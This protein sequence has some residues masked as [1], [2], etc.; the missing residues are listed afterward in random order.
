MR[1]PGRTLRARIVWTTAIVTALAMAAMIG[2]VVLVLNV[3]ATR[4]VNTTLHDRLEVVMASLTTSPDGSLSEQE[5]ANDDIDDTTWIFDANGSQVD[6]P[7]AGKRVQAEA[8]SLAMVRKR[9]SVESHDRVYLAAPVRDRPSGKV[10]G[11]VLVTESMAP[12]ETTRIA[13]LAVLVTLGLLV[14]AGSAAVAAWA[15]RRTLIPVESMAER[16][17]DWSER[18]LDARFDD[19]GTAD[20]F[21]VLGHTLNLLLDRVA[22]ALRKEQQLTS[23]LAHELRTPLTAIRGEAE[24]ALM[25]TPDAASAERFQRVVDLSDRMSTTITSLLAIARGSAG[26]P[27]RTTVADL[28]SAALDPR[29]PHPG[30]T[31]S[32]K[33][34]TED[35]ISAPTD[36]ALRALSPLVD[37]AFKYASTTVTFTIAAHSRSVDITVSDDGDGVAGAEAE[38]VFTSGYRGPTSDG[39]GLGLALSRRVARSLGGDVHLTSPVA[40]TSFTLTLPRY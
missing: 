13:V 16:A 4:S 21:A 33:H 22:G 25:G 37:N 2:A 17:E 29:P 14:T 7:R 38:T 1:K 28:V 20:E 3:S 30:V 26:S 40:P 12:Y 27:A 15:V 39:S 9:V 35:E 34:V 6:A 23:E 10:V 24:L 32:A 5:T 19:T 11:V 31:V 36:L 18:D 8:E